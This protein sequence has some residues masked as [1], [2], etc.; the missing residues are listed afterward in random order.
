MIPNLFDDLL[1][2]RF[3]HFV[4]GAWRAPLGAQSRLVAGA[5]GQVVCAGPADLARA[6]LLRRPAPGAGQVLGRAMAQSAPVLAEQMQALGAVIDV[7]RL[8]AL[9]RGLQCRHPV[10]GSIQVI[11]TDTD[12][13][14]L[15]RAL[16]C[17]FAAGVIHT[18]ATQDALLGIILSRLSQAAG[19]PPGS[20]AMLYA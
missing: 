13:E 3:T 19:L 10:T 14:G 11:C 16:A 17:G 15:G 7:P 4:G 20:Y 5:L 1:E 8:M 12:P 18:P 6:Q 2:R 9:G